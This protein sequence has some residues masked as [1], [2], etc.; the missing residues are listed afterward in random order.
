MKMKNK[1]QASNDIVGGMVMI[2]V[3]GMLGIVILTVYASIDDS[4]ATA[5]T[6]SAQ[7]TIGN[8]SG[9]YYNGMDLAANIPIVLAAGLLLTVIVGFSVFVRG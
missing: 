4:L 9:S 2:L 7:Q 1:G 6:T 3:I 5:T 8:F